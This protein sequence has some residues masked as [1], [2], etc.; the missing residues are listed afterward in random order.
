MMGGRGFPPPVMQMD[1]MMKIFALK[2]VGVLFFVAGSLVCGCGKAKNE[3]GEKTFAEMGIDDVIVQVN[4]SKLRKREVLIALDLNRQ[5]IGKVHNIDANAAIEELQQELHSYVPR[6]ISR[7]LLVDDA[8]RKKVVSEEYV[9]NRVEKAILKKAKKAGKTREQYLDGFKEGRELAE[10]TFADYV[11]LN[12]G[13]A[14]NIFPKFVVNDEFVSNYIAAI[15]QE[16]EKITASNNMVRARLE[17]IRADIL[18]GKTT[19][20]NE[21][22]KI[23][24]VNWD[25]GEVE[26]M[27]FGSKALRDAAFTLKEGMISPPIEGEGVFSLIQVV[28]I[29]PAVKNEKGRMVHPEKR[30]VYK[31]SL[32]MDDCVIVVP[33][34]KQAFADLRRQSQE[35]AVGD[36]VTYLITNGENR[37]IWPHGTNLWVKAGT[38]ADKKE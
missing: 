22:E 19:F 38:G 33:D 32:P 10:R 23:S 11:W 5:E 3:T 35:Q 30:H 17:K 29:T 31:M 28:K 4:D 13:M 36:Y 12:E 21:A 34:A 8:K 7:R 20:T 1:T 25:L 14:T 15:E 18:A 6:Y 27:E 9:S 2:T 16:N 37:I 26:R 24:I